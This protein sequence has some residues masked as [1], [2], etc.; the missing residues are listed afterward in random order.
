M[1]NT[2]FER[3]I[4]NSPY[5]YPGQH[6]ILDE[7]GQ[8]TGQIEPKR[9]RAEFITPIPK[10]KKRKGKEKQEELLLDEGLGLTTKRQAYDLTSI[11]NEV[12]SHVDAWRNLAATQWQ[13]TPETER[14]LKHWRHHE[15]G[16]V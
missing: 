3:P 7:S 1:S 13:V 5:E 14:L 15:F 4:I 2:F 9:R 8:P 11:I 12:R 6:W 16:G 10:P